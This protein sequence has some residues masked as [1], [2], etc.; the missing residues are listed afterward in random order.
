MIGG[1][2]PLLDITYRLIEKLKKRVDMP[3]YPIM[4]YVPPFATESLEKCRNDGIEELILF[5]YVSPIL[6]HHYT[7]ICGGYRA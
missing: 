3:I 1:K 2:S 4:R 7:I 5:S 6:H